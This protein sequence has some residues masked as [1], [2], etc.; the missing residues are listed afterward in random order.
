MIKVVGYNDDDDNVGDNDAES[1][2]SSND[3]DN[4]KDDN[5]DQYDGELW[6]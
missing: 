3:V 1:N 5:Y 4:E 2:I 6:S